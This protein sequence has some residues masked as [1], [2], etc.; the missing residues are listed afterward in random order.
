MESSVAPS[1]PSVTDT[2][3]VNRHAGIRGLAALMLLGGVALPLL[4]A[5]TAAAWIGATLALAGGGLALWGGAG[6]GAST[7]GRDMKDALRRAAEGEHV[8]LSRDVPVRGSED[9]RELARLFNQ[10]LDRM[11]G[12]LEEQRGQHLSVGIAAAHGRHLSERA[13]RDATRQEEES[14]LVFRS[15]DE[16]ATAVEQ[17]SERTQSLTDVNSRNLDAAKGSL[18]ELK[19]VSGQ[20]EAVTE[21][22]R[23]FRGTVDR[24]VQSSDRIRDILGTV[25]GFASQTNMLALNA[26]IEAARAGEHGGGFAVVAEEVRGLAGKVR[27]AAEEI[28]GLLEE[29]GTAVTGTAQG[30]RDVVD[31]TENARSAVLSAAEAFQRMVSDFE[32]NHQDLLMVGSGIEEMSVT[33]REA[34][35]QSTAIRD[36]GSRIRADME[37]AVVHATN[38]RDSTNLALQQLSRFHLGRGRLEYY[39]DVL[40]TRRDRLQT[41][42]ESLLDQGVDMFDSNYKPI[43]NTFP[44]KHD[45]SWARP[46]QRACQA[47][48]DEFANDRVDGA[49][50]W[51]PTDHNGYLPINRTEHSQPETGDK[52]VDAAKS[53]YMTFTVDNET[54]LNNLRKCTYVSMG[55]FVL[56]DGKV[57]FALF[58]PINLRGRRWGVLGTGLLPDA[59]G[60][61]QD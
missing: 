56:P 22:M 36:L 27:G 50:Y 38:Q 24:L 61:K 43:P 55:S 60:I 51:L 37:T 45:V 54:E 17:I 6:A 46:M 48:I 44:P 19:S 12:I 52:R 21:V 3:T 9:A 29:M 40:L 13:F 23:D 16:T 34:H 18:T 58:A 53:L 20:I 30:T 31:R 8:D 35:K 15:S 7:V 59:L 2:V 57:V 5:V 25:Q 32:A 41:V 10:F 11:R 4:D 28:D 26:A 33:N 42:M 47:L 39:I 49:L 1:A 14:E